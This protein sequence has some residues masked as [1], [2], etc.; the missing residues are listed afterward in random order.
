MA[1]RDFTANGDELLPDQTGSAAPQR[2]QRL[3]WIWT[4][5]LHN[6]SVSELRPQLQEKYTLLKKETFCKKESEYAWPRRKQGRAKDTEKMMVLA[7]CECAAFH[8]VV[9]DTGKL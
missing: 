8:N 6:R 1:V 4:G 9:K 2:V 5:S 3:P 7:Q